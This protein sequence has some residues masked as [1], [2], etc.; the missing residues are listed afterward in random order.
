MEEQ[1]QSPIQD[2]QAQ[3]ARTFIEEYLRNH[4]QT[5]ESV[6]L[7]P[8]KECKRLMTEA[9]VYASTKLA[10]LEHRAHIVQ[11]LHGSSQI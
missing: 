8:A 11:E 6:H 3:L 4:N 10:E 7:L 9:S 5:F 2:R 1:A